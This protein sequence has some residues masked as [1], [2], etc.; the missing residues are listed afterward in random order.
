[1]GLSTRPVVIEQEVNTLS[2]TQ[3]G[4]LGTTAVTSD[5][6][7]FR[8]GLAGA[9]TL[10]PGKVTQAPLGIANHQN[11]VVTAAVAVGA[12]SIT[13]TLGGTAATL[14]QYAGGYLNVYDASGVGQ[15]LLIKNH[16]AQSSTTGNLTLN[17]VDPFATALTTSAKVSLA[18]H[19]WTNV[20]ISDH[21]A[22]TAVVT[23]VP[24]VS[25]TAANYGWF[26]TRG[27]AS[28]LTNGTPAVGAGVIISA[29]TDGA[30]DVEGTST[31]TQR[32]GT[33]YSVSAVTAKYNFV[34]LAVL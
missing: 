6:R 16:P 26:Q 31:V 30:V 17:L 19:P 27:I 21:T 2:T 18:V 29:T 9:V 14:N 33:V 13:V 15:S 20:I 23:G 1:M 34:N 32:L 22:T 10:A 28:V 5:G 4:A 25:T 8:Y 7:E 12:Q 24:N 11:L 3:Q